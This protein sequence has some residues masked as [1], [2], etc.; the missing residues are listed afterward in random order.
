MDELEL[1]RRLGVAL[2]IG[3]LVGLERGWRSREEPDSQRAAGLRTFA[4]TGLV[5]GVAGALSLTLGGMVLGLAFL[6][7]TLGFAAFHYMEA[8]AEG[9]YGATSIVAGMLTF[10]LG[11][12]AVMGHLTAAIASGVAMT[13]LLAL[14]ERLHSLVAAMTFLEV[15]AV[16]TLVA[17]SFLLLPLLP[18]RPV[19]PWQVINP[20]VIWLMAITIAVISFGGYVAIKV[21]G[22]ARGVLVTALAGGL[23]SSTAVT[24]SFARL[25]RAHPGSSR[26]LAGG[27]LASGVVMFARVGLVA[28]VLNPGLITPL[29]VPLAVG[30]GVAMFGAG[31]QLFGMRDAEH[32]KLDVRNPLELGTALKL[33]GLIA[34]IMLGARGLKA[35]FGDAGILALAALSG[36]A[37]VDAITLSM[38]QAGG[39]DIALNTAGLAILIAVLVNTAAKA[40]LAWWEG[41]RA[42]GL[43]V[44]VVN[45][46]AVAAAFGAA[47]LG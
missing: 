25:A 12:F 14:R 10:L 2:A 21:L 13:L 9:N 42:V 44:S 4:L 46:A 30:G 15:R 24:L 35:T 45:G 32:P 37:D 38:A 1:V 31:L 28:G 29:L 20:Y 27:I 11:A 6:G 41:G 3:L 40:V 33:A 22:E 23:A 8:K 18:N 36:I 5:G 26:L 7:H 39:R 19:D 17:M 34:V 16:L 43:R 47:M